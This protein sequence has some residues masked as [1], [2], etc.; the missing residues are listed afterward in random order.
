MKEAGIPITI[1]LRA[2][3]DH[4]A[5]LHHQAVCMHGDADL[6]PARAFASRCN[7]SLCFDVGRVSAEA[8]KSESQELSSTSELE[9]SD[10]SS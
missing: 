10:S 5:A 9:A 7:T 3:C 2:Y 4:E 6:G 8:V 1:P